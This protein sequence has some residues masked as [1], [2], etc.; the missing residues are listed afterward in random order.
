MKKKVIPIFTYFMSYSTYF[1]ATDN[2]RFPDNRNEYL[3]HLP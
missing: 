1:N 3:R 2:I